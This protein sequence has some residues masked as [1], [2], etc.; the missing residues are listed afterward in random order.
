[1]IPP[2]KSNSL[3]CS[4]AT[5]KARAV[6]SRIT[7]SCNYKIVLYI[8]AQW[9]FRGRSLITLFMTDSV[10]QT[11]VHHHSEQW[12]EAGRSQVMM[13][14][15]WCKTLDDSTDTSVLVSWQAMKLCS[16]DGT[17]AYIILLVTMKSHHPLRKDTSKLHTLTEP[18][19]RHLV[20]RQAVANV[21][22]LVHSLQSKSHLE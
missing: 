10:H 13:E 17:R 11:A 6:T 1:M 5:A 16:L 19:G 7:L 14:Y 9:I 21:K 3:V 2:T 22:T 15:E 18:F 4:S 20:C 12:H 8:M